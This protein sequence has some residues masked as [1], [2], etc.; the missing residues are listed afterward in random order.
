MSETP[1]SPFYIVTRFE[2]SENG[3]K[4]VRK[5]V[6][7]NV[8]PT[9]LYPRRIIISEGEKKLIEA[10]RITEQT[11]LY[12]KEKVDYCIQNQI[13]FYCIY[14][15]IIIG[16]RYVVI[17]EEGKKLE[18]YTIMKEK[19]KTIQQDQLMIDMDNFQGMYKTLVSMILY[20]KNEYNIPIHTNLV[21]IPCSTK[22]SINSES[23][24]EETPHNNI[25][26]YFFPPT[27]IKGNYYKIYID[28]TQTL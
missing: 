11:R 10:L 24:D 21:K 4:R 27:Q 14:S 18:R 26:S 12:I 28:F 7:Q 22:E 9:S 5:K 13:L 2:S 16:E 19:S 3:R 15:F 8:Q 6:E 25:W 1:K 20:L 23:G 17:D